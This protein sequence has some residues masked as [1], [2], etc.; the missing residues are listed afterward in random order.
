MSTTQKHKSRGR[1]RKRRRRVG[2][3][4]GA[5]ENEAWEDEAATVRR[6]GRNG[7]LV[8]GLREEEAGKG[9]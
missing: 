2:W 7:G 9:G 4:D 1:R 5:R 6:K 3:R 8:Q